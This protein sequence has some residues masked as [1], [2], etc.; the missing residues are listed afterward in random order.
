MLTCIATVISVFS[1][2]YG[3]MGALSWTVSWMAAMSAALAA[4]WAIRTGAW[5]SPLTAAA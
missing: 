4:K 2:W 1:Q 5:P 3:D